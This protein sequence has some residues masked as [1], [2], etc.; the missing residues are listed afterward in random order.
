MST[1]PA[2][3][4]RLLQAT[5]TDVS[6]K[7]PYPIAAYLL[8][9]GRFLRNRR[10]WE[11]AAGSAL[12]P[13][14]SPAQEDVSEKRPYLNRHHRGGPIVRHVLEFSIA[15]PRR[16]TQKRP[17]LPQRKTLPHVPP[18][19]VRPDELFFVTV[20]CR[21]RGANVLARAT[22]ARMVF[23]AV[24]RYVADGRWYVR[25]MV[26]MPDHVHALA[27][28]PADESLLRV[29]RSWKRFLARQAGLEWQRDYFD[30]RLRNDE[31]CEEKCAYI[32]NNPVR[33]GLVASPE[34]WPYVWTPSL[35]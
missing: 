12:A 22:V 24:E 4:P 3:A 21:Q 14:P 26:L 25:L 35:R 34:L 20:C 10:G 30:H 13:G 31:S 5:R 19:W 15:G 9:V 27:A 6:E 18:S 2:P 32:R 8:P 11:S 17:V 33:A 28:V 23:D 16:T 1:L 29:V 7:R